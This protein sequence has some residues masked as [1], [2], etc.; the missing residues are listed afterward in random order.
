[1]LVDAGMGTMFLSAIERGRATFHCVIGTRCLVE[2]E[3]HR[4]LVKGCGPAGK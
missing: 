3:H 2:K 4:V 1:M